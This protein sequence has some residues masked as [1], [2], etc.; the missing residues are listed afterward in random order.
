MNIVRIS[1]KNIW[2][3]KLRSTIVIGAIAVGI[4]SGTYCVAIILGMIQGR[5]D[6]AIHKEVGHIQM[7]NPRFITNYETEYTIS[8]VSDVY[9]KIKQIPQVKS[10]ASHTVSHIQLSTG[11]TGSGALVTGIDPEREK[12]ISDIHKC[13]WNSTGT[14]FEEDM[15]MP[16]LLSKEIAENLLLD[17]YRID[18]SFFE[19]CAHIPDS[20]TDKLQST[21][22]YRSKTDFLQYMKSTLSSELLEKYKADFLN[23]ALFFKTGKKLSYSILSKDKEVQTGI[24]KIAGVYKTSNSMFDA[25]NIFM[26]DSDLQSLVHTDEDET[27]EIQILLHDAENVPAVMSQLQSLFPNLEIRSWKELKPDAGMQADLMNMYGIIFIIIIL[28]ALGFGIVN[29]MLMVVLERV[30]EIGMLMA[31]GMNKKRVYSMILFETVLLCLV[32]AAIGMVGGYYVIQATA[33]GIDISSLAQ[34][35]ESVGYAPVL[36]PQLDVVFFVQVSVLTIITGILAALYP[37]YKAIKY[38]PADAIRS[39]V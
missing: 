17:Y 8:N 28:G 1:W 5:V 21:R 12:E 7:H 26:L 6:D 16:V 14:Y 24:C 36:Y 20:V 11:Y 13:L 35:L 19:T 29:T 9:E 33:S 25:R 10:I 31:I 18:S 3:N 39:D 38:N 30:K 37:A 23:A 27:H 34:G 2:R 22:A 4:L 15:Y 32:G